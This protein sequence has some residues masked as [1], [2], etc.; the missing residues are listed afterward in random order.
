MIFPKQSS[1]K[2]TVVTNCRDVETFLLQHSSV[3][4]VLNTADQLGDDAP[5]K[6]TLLLCLVN[7]SWSGLCGL[8]AQCGR[9]GTFNTGTIYSASY[10]WASKRPNRFASYLGASWL[11][12]YC[13]S[14]WSVLCSLCTGGVLDTSL[15]CAS[16]LLKSFWFFVAEYGKWPC[17]NSGGQFLDWVT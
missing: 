13:W 14:C 1:K 11:V 7:L 10:V 12:A 9:D 2:G 6:S 4:S 16:I 3:L 5:I 17:F 15:G 8:S